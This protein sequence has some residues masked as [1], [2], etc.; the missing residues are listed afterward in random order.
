M[1]FGFSIATF[2]DE[3]WPSEIERSEEVGL[4]ATEFVPAS[5]SD[6][7]FTI[8]PSEFEIGTKSTW[9]IFLNMP[10][11]ME[12]ICYIKIFVPSDLT[13]E[14]SRIRANGMFAPPAGG[15]N[16]SS[17]DWT[18]NRKDTPSPSIR[19][20]GC[21]KESDVGQSPS[22]SL[23][24]DSIST[25]LS[26]KDSGNF[27]VKVYKDV[28]LDMEIANIQKGVYVEAVNLDPGTITEITMTP[29]DPAVQK[30]TVHTITFTNEH[31]LDQS[32]LIRITFPTTLTLPE[33]GTE[34]E[35]I[36]IAASIKSTKATVEAGNEVKIE[37]VFEGLP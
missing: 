14:L 30:V 12:T 29:E 23:L 31:A 11:P 37:N 18:L 2:D 8:Q 32:G 10:I 20:A 5:I 35:I 9:S 21:N 24:I 34:M 36:P 33:Y 17:A 25:P 28:N 3:V 15:S 6:S 1:W 26:I 16:L 13:F 4:D 7:Q 27:Y 22:G 19:F